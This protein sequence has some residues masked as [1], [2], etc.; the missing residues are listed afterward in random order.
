M[1]NIKHT[2]QESHFFQLS[3]KKIS[4]NNN[5][6]HANKETQMN[7]IFPKTNLVICIYQEH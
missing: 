3:K 2:L 5:N 4:S 1:S 6:L 7:I